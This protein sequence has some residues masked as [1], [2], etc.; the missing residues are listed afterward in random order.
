[1][2]SAS[3]STLSLNNL[4]QDFK[5]QSYKKSYESGMIGEGV[6]NCPN[7]RDVIY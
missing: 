4:K 3:K 2:I 1:M 7:K 5:A 6:K